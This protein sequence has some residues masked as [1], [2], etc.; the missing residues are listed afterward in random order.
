[1]EKEKDLKQQIAFFENLITP[2]TLL[3]I[4]GF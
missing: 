4:C 1:M 3:F 2:F